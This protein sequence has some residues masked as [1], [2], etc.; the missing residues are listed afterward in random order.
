MNSTTIKWLF[1]LLCISYANNAI[2]QFTITYDHLIHPGDSVSRKQLDTTNFSY[3]NAGSNV[4]WDYSTINFIGQNPTIFYTSGSPTYCMT[5]PA[6]IAFGYASSWPAPPAHNYTYFLSD[7]T[8]FSYVGSCYF[9]AFGGTINL[10]YSDPLAIS[11]AP[12]GFQDSLTDTFLATELSGT[13]ILD[14]NIHDGYS[15]FI[16][17][18]YGELR[19]PWAIYSNVARVKQIIY[20]KDTALSSP[21]GPGEVNIYNGIAF[22]WYD[23]NTRGTVLVYGEGVITNIPPNGPTT[24]TP[25]K[26]LVAETNLTTGL[27]APVSSKKSFNLYPNPS[28]GKFTIHASEFKNFNEPAYIKVR[29]LQGRT[30]HQLVVSDKLDNYEIDLTAVDKGMYI[31]TLIVKGTCYSKKVMIQ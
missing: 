15:Q 14:T 9:H 20:Q 28:N 1:V 26:V 4:I 25:Y 12:L 23:I 11:V 16:Y 19:L 24:N 29:D 31:V 22:S 30:I 13:S 18:A 3:G 5:Y 10:V 21:N 8:Q 7:S 17:D 6:N 27:Y 2:A